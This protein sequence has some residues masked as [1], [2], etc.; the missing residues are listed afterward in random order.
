MARATLHAEI[1][2]A[3]IDKRRPVVIAS[4]DD[5]RGARG[6]ATVAVI[7]RTRRDIPTEVP[8]DERDGLPEASVVNCDELVTVPKTE[9]DRRIGQ[10]TDDRLRT[11]HRALR[12][13]LA[14]PA[15]D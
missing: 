12:F 4:R 1:W 10:L 2:W 5:P 9:L 11:F 8:V 7:T 6:R 15:V 14:I 3:D 13:A